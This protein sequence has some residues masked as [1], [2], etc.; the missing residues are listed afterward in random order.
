MKKVSLA[1]VCLG[2]LSMA[3]LAAQPSTDKQPLEREFQAGG[4]VH[5]HL[6]P[7]DY[8]IVGHT[9]PQIRI[10]WHV[11]RP[12]QAGGVH[13]ET[14]VRGAT[15]TIRTHGPKNGLHFDIA[16]PARSDVDVDLG[17]GDIEVK[18]IE[19]NKDLSMWAGDVSID[20]G[21]ADLYREVEASVRFGDISAPP[22]Q[23]AKGGIFRS[24]RWTGNGRYSVHAKLFAGDLNL[25]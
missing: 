4:L 7:G 9:E 10:S 12:E 3:V 15:A 24:F 25:R 19:G 6:T 21:R 17:A 23:V 22:F 1:F 16:L 18:G 20:V 2:I 13:V 5:L 14:D 11:D 8:N